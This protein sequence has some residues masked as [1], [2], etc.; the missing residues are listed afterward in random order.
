MAPSMGAAHDGMKSIPSYEA[1][2]EFYCGGHPAQVSC[3]PMLTTQSVAPLRCSKTRAGQRQG[4][5]LTR[6]SELFH[7]LYVLVAA[8]LLAPACAW[9]DDTFFAVGSGGLVFQKTHGVAMQREDLFLSP[10][11]IRVRYEMRNPGTRPV[12]GQVA[13]PLPVVYAG[14][15][16]YQASNL[17]PDDAKPGFLAFELTVNGRPKQTSMRVWATLHG[18]DIT[19]LLARNGLD[20][21]ALKLRPQIDP[22]TLPQGAVARLRKAGA[23]SAEQGDLVGQWQTHVTFEWAQ[24]FPPGVTVVEHRY[25]PILGGAYDPVNESPG[26][27][28]YAKQY[29]LPGAARAASLAELKQRKQTDPNAMIWMSFLSFI[30]RTARNWQGPIGTLNV[31]LQTEHPDDTIALCPSNLHFHPDGPARM[32][33]TAKNWAATTD[34]DAMFV[35]PHPIP[36]ALP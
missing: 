14:D 7:S 8:V 11:E 31:T 6:R 19:A 1:V 27:E 22:A 28:P 17:I 12:S 26:L 24:T 33:A 32:V 3:T 16:H 30:L 9:A 15:N 36:Q 5:P 13:F 29:C 10:R 2:N 35:S 18:A 23:L 25:A 34:I 20:V 4:A 21:R